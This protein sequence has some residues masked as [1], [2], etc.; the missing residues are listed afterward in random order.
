VKE[1]VG[2]V[3]LT[4]VD[5]ER[6]A[7]TAADTHENLLPTAASIRL[8]LATAAS[9]TNPHRRGGCITIRSDRKG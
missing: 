5:L 7:D 6:E 2:I 3:T 1:Y 9:K 4:M 8:I